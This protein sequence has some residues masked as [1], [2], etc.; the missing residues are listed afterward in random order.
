MPTSTQ[1]KNLTLPSDRPLGSQASPLQFMLTTF[2]ILYNSFMN[3]LHPIIPSHASH[4]WYP[5]HDCPLSNSPAQTVHCNTPCTLFLHIITTPS[6]LLKF[7]SFNAKPF[8]LLT[9]TCHHCHT[10]CGPLHMTHAQTHWIN[11]FLLATVIPSA[12]YFCTY[13]LWPYIFCT[14]FAPSAVF[15]LHIVAKVIGW[16]HLTCTYSIFLTFY[17]LLNVIKPLS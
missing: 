2:Y 5:L 16:S 12:L 13:E 9:C 10:L 4:S 7:L 15:S 1:Q 3:Q 6:Y 14:N 8:T 17:G 11:F